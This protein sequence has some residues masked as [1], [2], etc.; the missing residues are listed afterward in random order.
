MRQIILSLLLV[1]VSL[2]ITL[3]ASA[4]ADDADMEHWVVFNEISATQLKVTQIDYDGPSIGTVIYVAPD[5]WQWIPPDINDAASLGI[6]Y[7]GPYQI[8]WEEPGEPTMGNIF[9]Y[10]P[11]NV[12]SGF[13]VLS[14]IDFSNTTHFS[15]ADGSIEPNYLQLFDA[16]GNEVNHYDVIF[17]DFTPENVPEPSTLLLLGSGLAG[18]LFWGRKKFKRI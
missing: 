3:P 12:A 2:I 16:S 9:D 18:L 14:D 10:D 7:H 8:Y 11:N 1:S 6:Y 17:G 15:T 4:L 13:S 5:H